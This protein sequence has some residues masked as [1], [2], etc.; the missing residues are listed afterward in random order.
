MSLLIIAGTAGS[1]AQAAS[2]KNDSPPG[3][4]ID[5]L[6]AATGRYVGSPSLAILP[7]G[8]YVASHDEFGPR[9]SQHSSAVTRVFRS[10]DRGQ[11]WKPLAVIQGQFWSTLF[12]H[13]DALYLMGTDKEYGNVVLRRSTDG[14][15]SWTTPTNAASGL[16]RNDGQYHCAPVPILAHNGRLWRAM[17]RRQPPT[18]WGITF[19]AG[20]FSAPEDADLLNAT[21]WTTSNFLPGDAQWLGGDFGGWLEGN[22]VLT[23]D[24]RVVDLLRVDNSHLPEKA[25]IVDITQDGRT[26]S[27]NPETGFV[28]FPGGAKKFTIRFDPVTRMYWTL[29]SVALERDASAGR[30]GAIRNTL[31]L[32][33]SPDLRAWTVRS[34][35]LHHRDRRRHGFQYVDWQFD[36]DDIVAVCRTAYDDREGGAHSYHDANFLTFHRFKHFRE[37]TGNTSTSMIEPT[38]GGNG[39]APPVTTLP[40][41][42]SAMHG[43]Q[44]TDEPSGHILTNSGVWSP[45]SQ[46]VVYDVRSDP[47]GSVFDGS[48]IEAVNVRTGEVRQLYR[49][50]N[51]AHCGVVTWQPHG[52][53][54]VFILGPEHPAPDWSY[55]ESHRHGVVVDWSRPGV[56]ENLDARD[57]TPPFTIGALRGGSHVH[58]WDLAGQWLSWTYND[59][60]VDC[61][62]RDVGVSIPGYPVRVSRDHPRNH[63]GDWFSCIVTRTTANPRPGSDEIQ[64]A[65]EPGWIGVNGYVRADGR[66]QRHA[67]AFQ[68]N[69]VTATGKTISEVFVADLPEDLVSDCRHYPAVAGTKETRPSPPPGVTQRRLTFTADRKYPG[70]QGPRHW[71]CSSPDGARIAFLMKDD[72]GIV[73]IWTTSPNGGTPEQ[74]THNPW[75]IASTLSWSPDGLWIAHVMNNSVF[76]TG[77]LTGQSFR[78]TRRCPDDTAPR[79]EACVFSPDGRQIAYVR[80][81]HGA[82]GVFNQVF[83]ARLD[84]KKMA[85]NMHTRIRRKSHDVVAFTLYGTEVAWSRSAFGGRNQRLRQPSPCSRGG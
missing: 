60:L 5:H 27:F 47:A 3:V 65:F 39:S 33:R 30:P 64:R 25:A 57:L 79:P 58:V 73:Q 49:S 72:T 85:G 44:V 34:I 20:M 83:V 11:S 18:G 28:D 17:E 59:A 71:L 82:A 45:D 56:A 1:L 23:P 4:V 24:G 41:G 50:Q 75:P 69:V 61:G 6:P 43:R 66:R 14:G 13:R 12:L 8:E 77:T 36:D 63:D 22:A 42:D 35:L 37:L 10:N 54:V 78:L 74:L 67:L 16:L 81:V 84:P 31:A 46:W 9:S 55:S 2:L 52:E 80:R 29:A 7:G 48:R 38:P 40:S 76:V 62:I 51:G 32:S 19:C 53:K 68:G 26:A 15:A 70:L 21:N